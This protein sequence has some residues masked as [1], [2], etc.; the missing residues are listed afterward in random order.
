MKETQLVRQILDYCQL[1]RL[2]FWRNQ[3]GMIRTEKHV[4]KMGTIG[5]PDIIGCYKGFFVG[6]EAKVGKN[7]ATAA[8]ALFGAKIEAEGG[9]Y[10]VVYSL[11]DFID[12]LGELELIIKK[13][14]SMEAGKTQS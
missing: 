11:E 8:Q 1:R 10:R 14:D 9:Y 3:S 6:V 4:I 12:F 5:S 13:H 7:K 2:I